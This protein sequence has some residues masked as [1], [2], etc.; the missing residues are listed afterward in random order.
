MSTTPLKVGFVGLST[1]GWAS[2][3]LGPS[4]I[5]PSL[6]DK[7]DLVAVSTTSEASA[8]ASAT[9]YAELVGHPIEAYYGDS[10]KIA[11]DP[12]LDLIAVAVNA[13]FHKQVLLPIIN[14]K[15]DFFVEW[16]AGSSLQD[17]I[18]LGRPL[19]TKASA[20]VRKVKELISS[21]TIGAIRSTNVLAHLGRDIHVWPPLVRESLMYLSQKKNGASRL[22][23]P[24]AH[25]LDTLT[26]LLGDFVSLSATGATVYPVGTLLDDQDKPTGETI[27]SEIPDH[28]AISG[29]LK[30]GIVA[31]LF[32]RGGY[33]SGEG[34]RQF[35]WEIDGD[36]GCIRMESN[37]PRGAFASISEPEL[38]LNGK[39][40][41][42]EG[43]PGG[44]F[45]SVTTAWKEY[46][47]HITGTYATID[48][49]VKNHRLLDAIERS[50]KEGQRIVL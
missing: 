21:G 18:E 39:K 44:A 45:D 10:S 46:A 3:V 36:E 34:R 19:A 6:R 47:E 37:A 38:Y 13:P 20:V 32:W 28:F 15:K 49:A 26:Y 30:H 41:D 25:Q 23:I 24:I 50:C 42:L 33:L 31:N 7:Y 1:T 29:I 35:V 8:Q 9:K 4:L 48:D 27:N 40:V 14:A 2:S 43:A 16:P 22:D 11:A 5:Q 17:T 12:D